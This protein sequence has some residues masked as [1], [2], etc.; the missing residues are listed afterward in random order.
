MRSRPT[1]PRISPYDKK[2]DTLSA[3]QVGNDTVT[4][5]PISDGAENTFFIFCP[6][7]LPA[8][9]G[10]RPTYD[11]ERSASVIHFT[12]YREKVLIQAHE[13]MIWRRIVVWSHE[14]LT[15]GTPPMKNQGPEG[16]QYRTRN[17]SPIPN[18]AALRNFLFTGTQGI[19]YTKQTIHQASL[20]R[21][22]VTP[23]YDRTSIINPNNGPTLGNGKLVEKK[24]WNPGGKLVYDEVES[25]AKDFVNNG[26]VAQSG[27]SRGNMYIFDI[28]NTPGV[29]STAGVFQPQGKTYWLQG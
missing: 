5:A 26:W 18:T 12:G 29:T 23:V 13:S 22:N 7:F 28:F 2:Y 17:I 16:L 4:A 21:A 19:D 10:N 11:H 15:A 24:F 6:T 1:R 25:G 8:K 9:S 27:S 14:K 3:G 20:N